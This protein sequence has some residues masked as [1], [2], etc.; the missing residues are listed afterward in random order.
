MVR[1]ALETGIEDRVDGRARGQVPGDAQRAL[2]LLSHADAE[3]VERKTQIYN[4]HQR[5]TGFGGV[6]YQPLLSQSPIVPFQ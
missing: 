1:R 6:S 3:R 2:I 4:R 5:G